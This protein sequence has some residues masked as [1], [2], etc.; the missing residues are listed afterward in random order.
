MAPQ[1]L[2]EDEHSGSAVRQHV[3]ELRASRR[4]VERDEGR[5]EPRAGEPGVDHLDP[6]L[7]HHRDA[8]AALD[9][10]RGERPGSARDGVA[11]L[12]KRSAGLADA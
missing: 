7:R 9:A 10:R 2:L 1:P 3:L 5:A 4:G 8:I 6:V 12:A 11:H